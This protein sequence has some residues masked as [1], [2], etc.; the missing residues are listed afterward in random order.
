MSKKA[1]QKPKLTQCQSLQK[2]TG[3]LRASEEF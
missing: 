2:L 3:G 1:Y